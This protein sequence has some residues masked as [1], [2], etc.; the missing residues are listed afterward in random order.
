MFESEEAFPNQ[1]SMKA[2]R[3]QRKPVKLKQNDW[4]RKIEGI[5]RYA[6]SKHSGL[7]GDRIVFKDYS[8]SNMVD[9]L[10]ENHSKKETKKH[11]FE[12]TDYGG[13]GQDW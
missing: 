1:N 6:G 2:L 9:G 7:F 8:S 5:V 4:E 13:L 11:I 10:E 12:A 3:E